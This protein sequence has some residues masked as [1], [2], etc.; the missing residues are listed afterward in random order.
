MRFG[1][2]APYALFSTMHQESIGT[3]E[4]TS[5]GNQHTVATGVRWDFA[6]NLDFKLQLSQVTL[7][8]LDDPAAFA[9]LQPGARVGDKAHLISLAL[10]F[11]F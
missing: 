4:L 2:F 11:L 7:D 1:R 9:N 8:S 6:K 3:S 10:D 5:L